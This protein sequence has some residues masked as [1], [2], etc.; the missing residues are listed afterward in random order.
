MDI[1]NFYPIINHE[2]LL[3]KLH[4]LIDNEDALYLVKKAIQQ[5]AI[6]KGRKNKQNEINGKGVPQGIPISNILAQIYLDD[7][8]TVNL[9]YFRYVDDV[10]IH[11]R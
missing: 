10:L 5:V 2:I 1:Q 8:D 4:K 7:L 3:Q 9:Q 6:P 11:S